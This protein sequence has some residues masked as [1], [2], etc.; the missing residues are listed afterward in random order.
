[1]TLINYMRL[2]SVTQSAIVGFVGPQ[3]RVEKKFHAGLADVMRD[4][5]I[6]GFGLTTLV[7]HPSPPPELHWHRIEAHGYVID[8]TT[9]ILDGET[10][11]K[12]IIEPGDK[13]IIRRGLHIEGEGEENVTYI[14]AIP[15]T[16]TL[17]QAFELLPQII[18]T[19]P[20]KG[21]S[22]QEVS[23]TGQVSCK[24]HPKHN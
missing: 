15:T 2:F 11:D 22:C 17:L 14:V 19:D 1:M 9:W 6:T 13:L 3:I 16:Q 8:G 21:H 10:G 12:L 23:L 7:S 5:A 20:I 4:I 18:P 24:A